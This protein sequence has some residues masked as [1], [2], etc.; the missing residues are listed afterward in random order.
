VED[1]GT[2]TTPTGDL[3]L[4]DFGLLHLWSGE[5]EPALDPYD[6]GEQVAAISNSAVDL[7]ILGDDPVAAGRAADLAAAAGRYVFDI[8][9]DH[10]QEIRDLVV[11]RARQRGFAVRVEPIARMPHR[12]R[13]ARLLD[14]S[15]NGVEVLYGGPWAVAVRGL[16]TGRPLPVRGVRM[17]EDGPYRERWHSIWVEADERPPASTEDIGYVGVDEARL[18]FADPDALTAWRT[19][20]PV[21]GLADLAFWGADKHI[22]AERTGAGALDDDSYGWT[23]LPVRDG[24]QR[25]RELYRIKES[26]G[27]R[28]ALDYRPHDDHHRLLSLVRAAPTESAS[29]QIGGCV[30]CGFFT[31]WGDGAFPVRRDLT[32]D[33]TLCRL[34]VEVG[35]QEIVERQREFE[36]RWFG[37]LSRVALVSPRV[38]HDGAPVRRMYRETS[39][40]PNDSGWWVFAGDES[41]TETDP[42]NLSVMPLRDLVAADAAL[43]SLLRTPAPAAFERGTGGEFVPVEPPAPRD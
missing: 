18:A 15:P 41:D 8:P 37:E 26:D 42:E 20:D 23:D 27:L 5:S 32:A 6:V 43:E 10:V 36:D 28:F 31:S 39:H 29:V 11:S 3:V 33:G 24:V 12:T 21:D 19:G 7:V 34:R 13:V 40:D 35:A 17:P 30:V 9:A 1:L 25:A 2:V 16:P 14:D 4:I 22:L 38:A